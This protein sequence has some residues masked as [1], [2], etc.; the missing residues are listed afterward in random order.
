MPYSPETD[1][2]TAETDTQKIQEGVLNSLPQVVI[3]CSPQQEIIQIH[4]N[5]HELF[6]KSST[7]FISQSISDLPELGTHLSSLLSKSVNSGHIIREQD[8]IT[9]HDSARSLD[10][11]I[12]GNC[13]SPIIIL[14]PRHHHN[15]DMKSAQASGLEHITIAQA[16]AHEIKN[17]LA[18]IKG[19]AQLLA[20]RVTDTN[21]VP[22]ASIISDEV[23]RIST[24]LDEMQSFADPSPATMNMA[25]IHEIIDYC[26]KTFTSNIDSNI[27]FLNDFDPSLPEA[28]LDK[29]FTIQVIQNLI[30]NAIEAGRA[31]DCHQEHKIIIKTRFNHAIRYVKDDISLHKL[32]IE[33]QLLDHAGG[34]PSDFIPHL[35]QPFTSSKEA[36]RGMGLSI[37][38]H[39]MEKMQATITYKPIHDTG[40]S[41]IIGSCFQL[42]FQMGNA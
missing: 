34:V 40:T 13:P 25:N 18:G 27:L 4:G 22:I 5:F 2:N 6:G 14:H 15:D 41:E 36:G 33:V 9:G 20:N 29:S 24:L 12:D 16:M 26:C 32:P 38:A 10:I 42:N 19:A 3:H 31:K 30:K 1:T 8:F 17:P 37:C 23:D 11:H 28:M 35:F 39:L 21:L 7:G